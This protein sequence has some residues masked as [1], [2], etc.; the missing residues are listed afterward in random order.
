VVFPKTV[1]SG[2]ASI[3]NN[4]ASQ[5]SVSVP[6]VIS[7][8]PSYV[9]CWHTL[10]DFSQDEN[11]IVISTKAAAI[12]NFLFMAVILKNKYTILFST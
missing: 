9:F 4:A 5:Y 1:T 3:L 6:L 7:V 10:H 11:E 12:I 8:L 2:V